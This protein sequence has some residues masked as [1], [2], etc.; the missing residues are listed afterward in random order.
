MLE[1]IGADLMLSESVYF[2]IL[3][4]TEVVWLD[5]KL[6]FLPERLFS[7][8]DLNESDEKN[9]SMRLGFFFGNIEFI[10][11]FFESDCKSL[12][13]SMLGKRRGELSSLE[14]DI[15]NS[16]FFGFSFDTVVTE[17]KK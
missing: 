6:P 10:I 11:L 2:K 1:K 8:F 13:K 16:N 5:S 15:E 9:A 3:G 7:L 14:T 4:D 12:G 17:T